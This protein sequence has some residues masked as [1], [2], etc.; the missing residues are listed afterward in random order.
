MTRTKRKRQDIRLLLL[1]L[2]ENDIHI[3]G[4]DAW[5]AA[6]FR[7]KS[8]TWKALYALLTTSSLTSTPILP[9]R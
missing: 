7:R 5:R 9:K 1:Y 6:C 4:M 2:I 8:E 3:A